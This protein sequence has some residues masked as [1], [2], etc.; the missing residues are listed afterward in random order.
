MKQG[1]CNEQ[2]LSGTWLKGLSISGTG[3]PC[4]HTAVSDFR[5]KQQYYPDSP[6]LISH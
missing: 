1:I 3:K 6:A 5:V 4:R 2:D